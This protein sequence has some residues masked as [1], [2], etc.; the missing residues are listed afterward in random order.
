MLSVV[1]LFH[2]LLDLTVWPCLTCRQS[3]S[4][5]YQANIWKS[6]LPTILTLFYAEDFSDMF[7]IIKKFRQHLSNYAIEKES[8][9]LSLK[10]IASSLLK[11]KAVARANSGIFARGSS[12]RLGLKTPWKD[13]T[14]DFTIQPFKNLNTQ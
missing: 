6:F 12:T 13:R 2:S 11:A 10:I 7:R 3:G 8:E 5:L 4:A 14:I 9:L 1:F